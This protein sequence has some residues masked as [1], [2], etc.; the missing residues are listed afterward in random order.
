M[1]GVLSGDALGDRSEVDVGTKFTA[2]PTPT[3]GSVPWSGGGDGRVGAFRA[4]VSEEESG[5][6]MTRR[7]AC[8]SSPA[9]L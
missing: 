6:L 7:S 4:I 5:E 2:G 1:T 8:A 9:D 3:G